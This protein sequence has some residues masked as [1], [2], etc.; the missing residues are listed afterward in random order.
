MGLTSEE[1]IR[2]QTVL[3]IAKKMLVAARTAP[4]AKG[5]DTTVM[6]MVDGD[7]IRKISD[8]LK[9]LSVRYEHP[10][11][12]RDAENILHAEA[13]LLFGSKIKSIGLKKCGQCGFKN[14]A[15]KDTHPNIP[16][17]YNSNDLGIAVGSAVSIAADNRI[18][19][20]IMYT[21]GQAVL[22]MKLLGE[23]VKMVLALPL[24]VSAKNP[25]F[26]RPSK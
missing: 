9:E 23:D 15:E 18:D 13:M 17:F 12:L 14:C 11:F 6:V 3:D 4:K 20:R 24:S 22:E 16:C 2:H 8:K 1:N 21:V 5:I 25:F 26:D 7:D 10:G 19:N